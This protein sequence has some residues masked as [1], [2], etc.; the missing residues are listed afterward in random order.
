MK[1]ICVAVDTS[2]MAQK[3]GDFAIN[4]ARSLNCEL[5]VIY[6]VDSQ[7]V[8]KSVPYLLYLGEE[9][10][11]RF[12]ERAKEMG[13][14]VHKVIVEGRPNE[15]IAEFVRSEGFDLLIIGSRG[16]SPIKEFFLG[17]TAM[18]IVKSVEIPVIIVK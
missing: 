1:K 2:E 17:G 3:V 4:L 10:L 5:H 14:K 16:E 6:V 18:K 8:M 15:K 11:K 13:V 7:K 9:T 12:E